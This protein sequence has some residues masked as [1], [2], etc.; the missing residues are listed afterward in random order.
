MPEIT[1][2]MWHFVL[3]C[4]PPWPHGI[5]IYIFSF[6]CKDLMASE[7]E[8]VV[9]LLHNPSLWSSPT[10]WNENFGNNLEIIIGTSALEITVS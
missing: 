2:I 6:A 3:H 7:L 8:F 10:E 9:S 4:S 1:F 5:N